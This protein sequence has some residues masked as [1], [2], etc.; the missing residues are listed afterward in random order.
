MIWRNRGKGSSS[1]GTAAGD[2]HSCFAI[3]FLER[4]ACGVGSH[5]FAPLRFLPDGS[6][7]SDSTDSTDSTN[8][9]TNTLCNFKPLLPSNRHS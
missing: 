1:E 7:F 9:T 2:V 8:I 4:G 6:A 5:G 3:R